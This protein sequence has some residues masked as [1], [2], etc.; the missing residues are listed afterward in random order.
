MLK[1]KV[2]Q[3]IAVMTAVV[4]STVGLA[5]IGVEAKAATSITVT[6]QEELLRALKNETLKKVTIKT[7]EDTSLEIPEGNYS[8]KSLVINANAANVVNGGKFKKIKIANLEKYTEVSSGNKI[9]V[10]DKELVVD[11]LENANLA[12]FILNKDKSQILLSVNGEVSKIQAKKSVFLD[13]EGEAKAEL[14]IE[15]EKGAEGTEITSN[16]HAVVTV[17]NGTAKSVKVNTKDGI[18]EVKTGQEGTTASDKVE[19][20][21]INGVRNITMGGTVAL[22]LDITPENA[23]NKEVVWSSRDEKI[24][25]VDE[26]GNVTGVSLGYTVIDCEV[27]DGSGVKGSHGVGV[28]GEQTARIYEVE[29]SA[30]EA[31]FGGESTCTTT[32]EYVDMQLQENAK[33]EITFIAK[34]SNGKILTDVFWY[35]QNGTL[36]VISSDQ[37]QGKYV[38]VAA[39]TRS[40]KSG[41]IH[42]KVSGDDTKSF[43]TYGFNITTVK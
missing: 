28:V 27:K 20:I 34:D 36:E 41:S 2:K 40:K 31:I 15:L 3:L 42:V 4:L 24:A 9:T 35:I 29:F 19:E 17:K 23:L 37:S 8:K 22:S 7:K 25:T 30:S 11:V 18:I 39:N 33:V 38:M 1:R 21:K 26:Y 13:I 32:G 10:T 16:N 5:E 43:A 12:K 6:T 14:S